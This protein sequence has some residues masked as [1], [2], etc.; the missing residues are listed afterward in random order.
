MFPASESDG[1]GTCCMGRL[2]QRSDGRWAGIRARCS[3][4]DEIGSL[5]DTTAG[6]PVTVKVADATL[7]LWRPLA[8]KASFRP[9]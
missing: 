8:W 5:L 6:Q 9:G 4:A 3:A 2:R 1:D 7:P